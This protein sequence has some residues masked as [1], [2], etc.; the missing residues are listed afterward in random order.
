MAAGW[1]RGLENI[2]QAVRRPRKS[3]ALL[4]QGRAK[5]FGG[6]REPRPRPGRDEKILTSWNALMIAGMARAARYSDAPNGS[7]R[8]VPRSISL[9]PSRCGGKTVRRARACSATCKDGRARLNA[10]LQSDY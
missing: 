9:S 8:R 6:A 5:L 1:T 7:R 4:A 3:G 10:Y 2:A